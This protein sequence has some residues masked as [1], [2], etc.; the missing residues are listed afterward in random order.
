MKQ[1]QNAITRIFGGE[2]QAAFNMR[3]SPSQDLTAP[4]PRVVSRGAELREAI[5]AARAA[6]DTVGLVPTMGALHEGHL[7]LVDAARAECDLT[8]VSIFVNPSQFSPTEDFRHYPRD[9]D[10]DLSLLERHGC[11]LVFAPSVEEMYRPD[12]ATTIDVGPLAVALEGQTRP[13]HFRG[14]AT[15]VMKLFQLAPAD[16]AYFGQKDYQQT[17]VMRQMVADLD[18]PIEIRVCPTVREPDGLAMSSRNAYLSV[19]ERH[20]AVVL[21]QSLR[22]A[23]ELVAQ[24][25]RSV[26][27]IRA[28]METHLHQAGG[29]ALEY[30]AFVADGT[31][32]PVT[33][34]A[35]PTVVALAAKVGKTRLIDNL[36]IG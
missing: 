3:N 23:E 7:S 32:T 5:L 27:S 28:K 33:T 4:A 14:V 19:E 6:G 30:I 1:R 29:I 12:A 2:K 24:G 36:R 22:L 34:I 9:L 10:R 8:V 11:D 25:E 16:F 18:V 13:T 35:G 20:S 15:V 26:A 21:S 31:I 17:L